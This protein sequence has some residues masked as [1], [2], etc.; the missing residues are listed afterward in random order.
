MFTQWLPASVIG[1]VMP[2]LAEIFD[3]MNMV[4]KCFLHVIFSH[5]LEQRV[6]STLVYTLDMMSDPTKDVFL[7][8]IPQQTDV[9]FSDHSRNID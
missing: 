7:R 9:S 1:H 6:V 5:C 3:N 8:A 2:S 4:G